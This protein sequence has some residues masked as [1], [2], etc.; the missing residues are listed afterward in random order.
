VLNLKREGYRNS[1]QPTD[2]EII[3]AMLFLTLF[4]ARNAFGYCTIIYNI[5]VRTFSGTFSNKTVELELRKANFR[6][7]KLPR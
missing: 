4:F 6:E 2:W 7:T 5:Y 1:P 3:F